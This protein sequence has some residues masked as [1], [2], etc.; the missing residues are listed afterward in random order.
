MRRNGG[1]AVVDALEAWG[2]DVVFGI[3]GV[4]TLTLYDALYRHPRIR[5]ITTRHEQ[6]A[7]FMADGYARA[8]GKVG[9]VFTTTGPA[10]VNALTPLGEAYA[11]S[12]PVLLIASGPTEETAGTDLGT[13]HEMRDQ[14]GML[15]KICGQGR[16]VN[17]VEDIPEAVSEAFAAMRTRRPRPYV[18]EV[19]LDVFKAEADLPQPQAKPLA[20]PQPNAELLKEAADLIRAA[21]RP[22]ILAGGGAQNASAEVV[23]LA[24]RIGAPVGLTANGLGVVPADHPLFLG[25][26]ETMGAWLAKADL[27]IAAGTRFADPVVR[28]WREAKPRRL[29]HLDIDPEVIGRRYPADV[30]LLGDARSGLQALCEGLDRKASGWSPEEIAS[31]RETPQ[32]EGVLPEI[33]RSLRQTLDRDAVV[34]SDMTM[35]CYQARRRFPVYAPRSFLSPNYYGALGFSVPAA[36][37]A[38]TACPHRQVVALCGD[39]GFLFTAQELS[40]ARQ[41]RLGLP[42]V[43]CNDNTYSAIKR[44]QDRDCG[45]RHIGVDLENPDF[46]Q[47]ARSFGVNA[48]RVTSCAELEVALQTALKADLPTVIEVF[49]P[50]FAP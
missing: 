20:P 40:T 49:L 45:G 33:L 12:S 28:S 8:S 50:E 19:P 34:T 27:L 7:A 38:R 11:E 4:H 39:G 22:L 21:S 9:V 3:P 15:E 37:G 30:G 44:A 14:F 42:I 25:R 18:L 47:F 36:I 16:R 46:V 41:Q 43:L 13:L 10:A 23:S 35:L 5:H 29:V 24:E 26:A 32:E 1:Q 48:A 17:R 31:A 2:V 6:G